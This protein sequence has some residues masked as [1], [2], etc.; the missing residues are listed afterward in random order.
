MACGKI[1][2][3]ALRRDRDQ[4][5]AEAAAMEALGEPLTLPEHL[6]TAAAEKQNLHKKKEAYQERLFRMI[7]DRTSGAF[8]LEAAM[9]WLGIPETNYASAK[10]MVAKSIFAL[11]YKKVR[12]MSVWRNLKRGDYVYALI[13]EGEQLRDVPEIF[14][15]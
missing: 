14:Y 13:P 6:W 3:E 4:L 12:V 8:T 11:G 1:D 5:W 9:A 10:V 15:H 7:G 2:L